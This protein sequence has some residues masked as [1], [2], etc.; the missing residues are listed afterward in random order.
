MVDLDPDDPPDDLRGLRSVERLY[1]GGAPDG[2]GYWHDA[3]GRAGVAPAL[4]SLR[5]RGG[6][7]D[8]LVG[9]LFATVRRPALRR[10]ATGWEGIQLPG[11]RGDGVARAAASNPGLAPLTAFGVS[12]G[13]VS[14]AAAVEVVE[15]P[16][17]RAVRR[18]DLRLSRR[19]RRRGR[20]LRAPAGKRLRRPVR[21][22]LARARLAGV[23][24]RH[25]T[26]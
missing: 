16:H 11:S 10:L 18:L 26:A 2:D 4:A 6:G 20:G 22:T 5:V 3:L 7:D 12:C 1:F 23:E 9:Q 13:P 24:P 21:E 17:L 14:A 15:S 8:A 25:P 19:S